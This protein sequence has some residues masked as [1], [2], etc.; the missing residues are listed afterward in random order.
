M[1]EAPRLTPPA[2]IYQFGGAQRSTLA[3]QNASGD[4]IDAQFELLIESIRATQE[5][6]ARVVRSD[7]ELRSGSV[8]PEALDPEF[9]TKLFDEIAKELSE[10][11]DLVRATGE[12][13]QA[14]AKSAQRAARD[15]ITGANYVGE[16][17]HRIQQRVQ[18]LLTRSE[19]AK[20]VALEAENRISDIQT[21]LLARASVL[22]Q[23]GAS[24]G[25]YARASMEWAEHM[26]GTLPADTVGVMDLT[27]EHWS[28]RWWAHQ[29]SLVFGEM[30]AYYQGAHDTPP[31]EAS[32]GNPLPPGALYF[33]LTT[34]AMMVWN[35]SS[36][37]PIGV[38]SKTQTMS[39]DYRATAN[40]VE[41]PFAIPDVHNESYFVDPINPEPI[42]V[43]KGGLRQTVDLGTG[44]G[45]GQAEFAVSNTN[46]PVH[47][48]ASYRL[49]CLF[50]VLTDS[51]IV[52]ARFWK[53][54]GS[55]GTSRSL[56]LYDDATQTLLG[57]AITNETPGGVGWFEATFPDPISVA[58][59]SRVGIYREDTV[60]D[61]DTP[62]LTNPAHT[63][64]YNGMYGAFGRPPPL[65]VGGSFYMIDIKLRPELTAG[66]LTGDY[67]YDYPNNKI[68]FG[69]PVASDTPVAIDIM[70]RAE[71]LAPGGITKFDLVDIDLDP[72]S[73]NPGY[74]DGT[75]TTFKLRKVSGGTPVT[76]A[77]NNELEV[78][79][80]GTYQQPGI[81]FH[82]QADTIVFHV[83]PQADSVTFIDYLEPFG[84]GGGAVTD[85]ELDCGVY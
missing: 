68:V 59:G 34:N 43:F 55:T 41:F 13:A 65:D 72:S 37:V 77:Q 31:T 30:A 16:E 75:R 56:W 81:D 12:E 26:P 61:T 21:S 44:D 24:A 73:G 42:E 9:K 11:R 38:P 47:A 10:I 14:Q 35:G 18:E 28:A 39:L 67:F 52:A 60:F 82:T 79:L 76:P 6:L 74:I 45:Y 2:R 71:T 62:I 3:P 5:V 33:D 40:Q 4:K 48:A 19:T 15:A 57:T 54:T 20:K 83:P 8:T 69:A 51:Q 36:W 80:D 58:A 85:A 70:V 23:D 46:Q 66:E 27:G 29:A 63:T 1:S 22:E 25:A 49:G 64:F 32:S 84:G 50:N 7:G 17:S 53:S 78:Y